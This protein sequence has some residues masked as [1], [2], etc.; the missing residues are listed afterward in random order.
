MDPCLKYVCQCGQL[1]RQRVR[2]T[3]GSLLQLSDT[4]S[5][6]MLVAAWYRYA[7][8]TDAYAHQFWFWWMS[9]FLILAGIFSATFG[10]PVSCLSS[11]DAKDTP[12]ELVNFGLHPWAMRVLS[13]FELHVLFFMWQVFTLDAFNFELDKAFVRCPP[14]RWERCPVF[15]LPSIPVLTL[16]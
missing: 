15:S 16:S 6:I 1:A 12:T 14:L 13:F 8:A 4:A 11:T 3:R 5:D 10:V 9:F 2:I 7:M